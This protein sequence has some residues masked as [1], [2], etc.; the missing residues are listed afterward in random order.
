L[1][2]LTQAKNFEDLAGRILVLFFFCSLRWGL[3]RQP[4]F[5]ESAG[6]NTPR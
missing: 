5:S 4:V 1:F 3:M 6:G 2:S